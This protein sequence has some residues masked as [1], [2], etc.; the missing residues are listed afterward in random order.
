[1]MMADRR[2]SRSDRGDRGHRGAAKHVEQ[3]RQEEPCCIELSSS[4]RL[5]RQCAPWPAGYIQ[6]SEEGRAQSHQRHRPKAR[7]DEGWMSDG[8]WILDYLT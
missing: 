3:Q 5:W 6:V 2:D 7:M 4:P 1:M 8:S